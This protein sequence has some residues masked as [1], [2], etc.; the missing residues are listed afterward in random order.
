MSDD[1]SWKPTDDF[2][3][4]VGLGVLFMLSSSEIKCSAP[5]PTTPPAVE[6]EGR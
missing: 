5:A 3:W 1:R 4:F 2:W 6:K